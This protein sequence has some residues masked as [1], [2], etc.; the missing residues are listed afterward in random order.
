MYIYPDL[1]KEL[2]DLQKAG[3]VIS[4][5]LAGINSNGRFDASLFETLEMEVN[6]FVINAWTG[7]ERLRILQSLPSP[8]RIPRT[9]MYEIVSS[10][11]VVLAHKRTGRL[12]VNEQMVL[13]AFEM[14]EDFVRKHGFGTLLLIYMLVTS[15]ENQHAVSYYGAIPEKEF[16]IGR[17]HRPWVDY[18]LGE[19]LLFGVIMGNYKII[20]KDGGRFVALTKFGEESL[21]KASDV[22]EESGYFSQ[23]LQ[24]LHISQFSRFS[25]YS[26]LA[27]R[28]WPNSMDIRRQFLNWSGIEPGMNVLELGCANG[29]FTFDGGLAELV[30]PSGHVTSIDP[31]AAM[32]ERALAEKKSKGINWVEF[33]QGRAEE[34]PYDDGAFDAVIGVGFLHFTDIDVSIRE[35]KRVTRTG[36]FVTSCH[37][38]RT[39]MLNEPFMQEWFAPILELSAQRDESP[40]DYLFS[41]NEAPDKFKKAGF[42]ELVID[43][44]KLITKLHNPDDVIQHFIFG[45]GWMQEELTMLPW[46]AREEI[47]ENI[48]QRGEEICRKYP[49]EQLA[50]Y[51]P[52]QMLKG[53][54]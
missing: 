33:H 41:P 31:S 51:F 52:M 18:D 30:G 39:P 7:E 6:S 3:I 24:M 5:W 28:V 38:L 19:E 50:S 34:I 48:Q 22:L 46:K 32:I 53:T 26:E 12:E 9:A 44:A 45:V 35:M 16:L 25:N 20:I 47:I 29:I 15:W 1:T 17:W 36:G 49:K 54:T 11:A 40:R 37:P 23:R 43:E 10:T 27:N 4:P 13:E 2:K 21:K 42:N 8:E 14:A